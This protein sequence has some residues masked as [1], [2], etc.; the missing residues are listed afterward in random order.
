M[1]IVVVGARPGRRQ[2]RRGAPR[3]GLRR[4]H[5]AVRRRAAPAL[6][7]PAAVQGPA[8]RHRRAGL[9]LRP[10]PGVVRRAR[11][12][13]A[14]RHGGHR[15]RPRPAPVD[16]RRRPSR[17]TTGCC[18]PPA[19]APAG[20]PLADASGAPRRLPA[21]PRRLPRAQGAASAEQLV[22]MSAPAG[23]GSRSPSAARSR[24][25]RGHRRRDRSS[26]RCSASSARASRPCSPTCTASTAS[27][28]G[29]APA[30]TRSSPT[31]T[32]PRSASPTAARV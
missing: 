8:A 15:P 2:G 24:R 25:R 27:T 19:S 10:R 3:P 20:S 29:S 9:G 32:A 22:L 17:P 13:P 1:N 7:T 14:H 31:A 16:R 28:C 12:R 18:W 26:S 11:R 4:R 21:H 30:S 6:R 23:S 5:H